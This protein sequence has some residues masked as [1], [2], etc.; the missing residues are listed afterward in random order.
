MLSFFLLY[1]VLSF[2]ILRNATGV[3]SHTLGPVIS[4]LLSTPFSG[5][6]KFTP[7][8]FDLGT[9][10]FLFGTISTVIHVRLLIRMCMKLLPWPTK[11][12]PSMVMINL[13]SCL[14]NPV[15]ERPKLLKFA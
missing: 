5:L 11:D 8:K 4:L 14:A 7:I 10:A 9:L 13:F 1:R 2:T 6:K 15:P 3:G 12:L